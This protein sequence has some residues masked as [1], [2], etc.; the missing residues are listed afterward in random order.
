MFLILTLTF[1]R[2]IVIAIKELTGFIQDA[3]IGIFQF[4]TAMTEHHIHL[5]LQYQLIKYVIRRLCRISIRIVYRG[6]SGIGKEKSRLICS[7]ID[8]KRFCVS[9]L[10]K[11]SPVYGQGNVAVLFRI[12]HNIVDARKQHGYMDAG[13]FDICTSSVTIRIIIG[14]Q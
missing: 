13:T 9:R 3:H 12:G 1:S 2:I 5:L 11:K 4:R 7:D 8:S 14:I 10:C 6:I